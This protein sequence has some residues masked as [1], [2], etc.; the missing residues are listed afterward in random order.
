[1]KILIV[2]P[3]VIHVFPPKLVDGSERAIFGIATHGSELF[4]V[5]ELSSTVDVYRTSDFVESRHVTVVGMNNPL[6]LVACPHYNCLYISD[7]RLRDWR[8][9]ISD[10]GLEGIHRVDLSNCSV[11]K[12]SVGNFP[13]GL[14]VTS[15]H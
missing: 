7:R 14:S 10:Y 12:W 11:T 1:M 15:N 3:E 2:K 13:R 8:L 5:R 4:V 9:D 6:S